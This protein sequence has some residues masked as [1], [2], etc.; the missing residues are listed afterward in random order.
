MLPELHMLP[1]D[2]ACFSQLV[3]ISTC[4]LTS[5]GPGLALPTCLGTGVGVG[6]S[7]GWPHSALFRGTGCATLNL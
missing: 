2:W 3:D 5:L 1:E 6:G 7:Q 4:Q